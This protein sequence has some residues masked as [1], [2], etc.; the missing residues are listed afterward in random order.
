LVLVC[1]RLRQAQGLAVLIFVSPDVYGLGSP[2]PVVV[3]PAVVDLP[4]SDPALLKGRGVPKQAE[5]SSGV[6]F[7]DV[8]SS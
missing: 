6:L 4:R 8:G 3:F 5:A 2:L 7:F 1:L